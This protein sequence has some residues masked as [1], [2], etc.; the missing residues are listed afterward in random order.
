MELVCKLAIM[1]LS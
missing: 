1:P